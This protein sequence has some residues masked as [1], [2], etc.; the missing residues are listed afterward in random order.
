MEMIEIN[1]NDSGWSN[2]GC[3]PLFVRKFSDVSQGNVGTRAR[4]GGIL[5]DGRC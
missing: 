1:S 4:C 2:K 3:C 5:S